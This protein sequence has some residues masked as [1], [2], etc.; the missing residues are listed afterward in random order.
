MSTKGKPTS[1]FEFDSNLRN[2]AVLNW[3][4]DD[5]IYDA[6]G[7]ATDLTKAWDFINLGKA[8]L[9][10]SLINI[11][12]IIDIGN[13]GDVADKLIFPIIF[14]F[15]QGIELLLKAGIFLTERIIGTG[16][17]F[18]KKSHKNSQLLSEL[19]SRLKQM[20][21]SGKEL[22]NLKA[23][24]DDFDKQAFVPDPAFMR[25]TVDDK[26]NDQ[27]YVARNNGENICIKIREFSEMMAASADEIIPIIN[28]L[29][30]PFF[31]EYDYLPSG[32]KMDKEAFIINKKAEERIENTFS[33]Y[34]KP[35]VVEKELTGVAKMIDVV[36]KKLL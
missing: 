21:F 8:Y 3:W 31:E 30:M 36:W 26:G 5:R 15:W 23:L 19:I 20:K 9:G 11:V 2:N 28:F 6:N 18:P 32:G 27:F 24:L 29:A 35:L 34:D 22:E 4:F 12:L 14:T 7:K 33:D 17:S 1:I 25:Y 16:N 13:K 10:N